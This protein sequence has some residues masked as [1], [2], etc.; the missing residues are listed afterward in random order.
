M[1]SVVECMHQPRRD[2]LGTLQV[3][4]LFGMSSCANCA[5]ADHVEKTCRH[6]SSQAPA[7]LTASIITIV[8]ARHDIQQR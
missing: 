6:L 1:V 8:S 5:I 3:S 2:L 4:V 7:L